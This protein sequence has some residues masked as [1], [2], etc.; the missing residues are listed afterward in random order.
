MSQNQFQ[1]RRQ[2]S[3]ILREIFFFISLRIF[4]FCKDSVPFQKKNNTCSTNWIQI[5]FRN[6]GEPFFCLELFNILNSQVLFVDFGRHG[7]VFSL[8][9]FFP[10]CQGFC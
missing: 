9:I 6:F 1:Y 5:F 8:D 4:L 10:F 3:V 2:R 7:G